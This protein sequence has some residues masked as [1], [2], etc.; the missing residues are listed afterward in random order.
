MGTCGTISG[1][2]KFLKEQNPKVRIIGVDPEGSLFYDFFHSG[3][4][5]EPHVYKV[6]GIGEDFFPK[7]LDWGAVDDVVRV[8]DKESFLMA[9]RLAHTE[10]IFAGGSSGSAVAGAL[11]VAE[12]LGPEDLMVIFLPDGGRQY[13]GKVYN[14]DWM[15]EH[16][17]ITN[18]PP[19]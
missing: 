6:E 4:L 19:S 7:V 13:L 8:S 10:G 14:D 1:T 5:V 12:A 9:R 2:G 16:G 18:S 11:R 17:F 15:R 3:T